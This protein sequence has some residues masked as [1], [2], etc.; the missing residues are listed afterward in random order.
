MGLGISIG[1]GKER[2][3]FTEKEE[4]DK[5]TDQTTL[6]KTVAA[7]EQVG[8]QKTTG[9]KTGEVTV[10]KTDVS[11]SKGLEESTEVGSINEA[12]QSLDPETQELLQGLIGDLGEGGLQEL[13]ASLTSRGLS[14]DAD[15]AGLID[16]IVAGAR[17]NLEERLGQTM[18]GFARA[19]GGTTQN[20]I[21]QQLGLKEGARVEREVAEL[22]ATLGL[23]TRQLVTE[24]QSNAAQVSGGLLTQL[25]GLLKGSQTTRA[26]E[27]TT[28]A[29]RALEQLT[30]TESTEIAVTEEVSSQLSESAL[31]ELS[32]SV[33]ETTMQEIIK[34]I[35]EASGRGKTAGSGLGVSL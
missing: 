13:T 19:A 1:G 3:S 33:S 5:T 16:P 31:T 24:E 14:A 35:S 20:T 2:S 34:A 6:A 32:E 11:K 17:G 8:T 25:T 10:E 18:Q 22:A 15:L 27:T 26:G 29:V 30:E 23:E 28:D 12:I 21:V 9:S 7:R 4:L